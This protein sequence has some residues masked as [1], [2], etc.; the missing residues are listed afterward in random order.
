MDVVVTAAVDQ[1][2]NSS[3]VIIQSDVP[4]PLCSS[5]QWLDKETA[6]QDKTFQIFEGSEKK[7]L[8]SN[9]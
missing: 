1:T 8:C 9:C 2:M 7:L 3:E 5:Y 4:P 6:I